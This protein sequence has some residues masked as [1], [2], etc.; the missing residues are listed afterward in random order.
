MF[1]LHAD[2]TLRR[3][4]TLGALL[5]VAA[6][7]TLAALLPTTNAQQRPRR[8]V[9]N[10][11]QQTR[12]TTTTTT[13]TSQQPTPTPSTN[14]PGPVIQVK[15]SSQT[16]TPT[17]T[18]EGQ[19][20][21]PDELIT[22]DTN[23]VNLNVRVIDRNNRPVHDVQQADFRVYEDSVPQE[24]KF[25]TREEVPISYG[26]VVDNSGSMRPLLNQVIDAAKTIINSNKSGDETFLVRFISSDKIEVLQDFTADENALMDALDNLYIEGGQT[27]IIDA[28]LLSAERVANY[29]KGNDLNDRRRRALI[30]VTD[31]EDRSS[32]YKESE[33]FARLREMDVQ[34]YVIG[35]TGE[36]DAQNGGLIRK[37]T[38]DKAVNLINK[39]A[40]ETGGRAFFPNSISELPQIAQ[41]ITRD[42]RTQYVIG[43]YPTNKARDGQFH[44]IRVQIASNDKRDK[45]IAI[46]RT[47]RIATAGNISAPAPNRN[48]LTPPDRKP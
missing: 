6:C 38:K 30:L 28:T 40:T 35:F 17:P 10:A 29:K 23:L 26:L 47:G 37:S 11:N 8:A 7:A 46:T 3:I 34:L 36:L 48:K 42:L 20:I 18:P 39:L 32:F 45:R 43:Y 1:R 15:P 9:T 41:D 14:Q 27:A 21:N 24:I 13:Q 5:L 31:G 12:P 2:R 25:F 19:E 33:L 44:A 16:P 22:I 4:A